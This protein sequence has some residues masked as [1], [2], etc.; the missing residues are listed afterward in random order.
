MNFQERQKAKGTR[1]RIFGL[2]WTEEIDIYSLSD[3]EFSWVAWESNYSGGTFRVAHLP[4]GDFLLIE[5]GGTY[6]DPWDREIG[7][8]TS[9]LDAMMQAGQLHRDESAEGQRWEREIDEALAGADEAERNGVYDTES[10]LQNNYT[11]L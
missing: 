5:Q 9:P 2:G 8:F 10:D 4:D 6:M 11:E 7:T 1:R 3:G